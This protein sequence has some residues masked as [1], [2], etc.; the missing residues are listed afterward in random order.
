M[1]LSK[2]LDR[3]ARLVERMASAQGIDLDEALQRAELQSGELRA[4]VYRCVG[5]ENVGTCEHW[6]AEHRDGADAAPDYCRN[7][8]LFKSLTQKT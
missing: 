3:H 1:S 6:L 7:S 8:A 5:C 2:K 4:G